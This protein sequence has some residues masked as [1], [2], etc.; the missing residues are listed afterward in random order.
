MRTAHALR[1]P[2]LARPESTSD[3]PPG[4]DRPIQRLARATGLLYLILA[5]FGMFS[6]MVLESLV[7]GGRRS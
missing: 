2:Q 3:E 7:M 4:S 6:A 5:V 1:E